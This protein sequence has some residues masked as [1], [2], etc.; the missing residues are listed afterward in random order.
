MQA[1][2]DMFH[3]KQLKRNTRFIDDRI[4][5]L[6]HVEISFIVCVLD[7]SAPPGDYRQLACR[8]LFT[9]IGAAWKQKLTTV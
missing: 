8:E 5:L 1:N 6:H 9:H 7:P 4:D 3:N 2:T